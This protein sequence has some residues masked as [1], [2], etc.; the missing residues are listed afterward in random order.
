M[1]A[2]IAA[3]EAA[4]ARVAEE[5]AVEVAAA[6][7]AAMRAV[8]EAATKMLSGSSRISGASGGIGRQD[9][10]QDAHTGTI[11]EQKGQ[12]THMCMIQ[13]MMMCE[14]RISRWGERAG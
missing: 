4:A 13:P 11:A 9:T 6:E 8:E 10:G 3:L 7:A 1:T 12:D 14:S 5:A 2:K